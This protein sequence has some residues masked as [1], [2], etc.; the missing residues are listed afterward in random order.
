MEF[1]ELFAGG[2]YR[3]LEG[4]DFP[5]QEV[6]CFLFQARAFDPVAA[7]LR[8]MYVQLAV[9]R[10]RDGRLAY[11][12]D[13]PDRGVRP[14]AI[15]LHPADLPRLAR[16][17]RHVRGCPTLIATPEGQSIDLQEYAS[18]LEQDWSGE[19]A[20]ALVAFEGGR[21]EEALQRLR[22]LALKGRVPEA[23]LLYGRCLRERGELREAL[24]WFHAAVEASRRPAGD[25][26]IPFAATPLAE[27]G[28]AF[29]R[30]GLVDKAT[31]CLLFALQ[32]RPNNPEA[33]LTFS[34]LFAG[35]DPLV[36]MGP[37]RVLAL[38]GRE[39][40]VASFLGAY[41]QSRGVDAG[42]L[43]ARARR[44]SRSVDLARWPFSSPRFESFAALE[45]GLE[46][47]FAHSPAGGNQGSYRGRPS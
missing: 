23:A 44:M 29:K 31:H 9:R 38:G 47:L 13:L 8:G 14:W 30:L 10:S 17:T 24:D 45:R 7:Q 34:S 41:A 19:V 39:E 26:L 28:V 2:S 3:F 4:D 27:M 6:P 22:P 18:D 46:G 36:L 20:S 40:L 33:L 42:P 25:R 37:A 11:C 1:H 35:D 21:R 12:L 15:P 5:G 16:S 32:L 43:L